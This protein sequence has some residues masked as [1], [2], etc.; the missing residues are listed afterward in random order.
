MQ[1]TSVSLALALRQR[2]AAH[3]GLCAFSRIRLA[4]GSCDAADTSNLVVNTRWPSP[5][6]ACADLIEQARAAPDSEGRRPSRGGTCTPRRRHARCTCPSCHSSPQL[7]T[8]CPQEAS[9]ASAG[10]WSDPVVLAR[11]MRCN[12]GVILEVN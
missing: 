9:P 7:C 1:V 10:H 4:H 3:I 11:A 6:D 12:A 2:R 5:H 8:R